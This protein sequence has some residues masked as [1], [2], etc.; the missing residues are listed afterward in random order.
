[1]KLHGGEVKDFEEDPKKF[2]NMDNHMDVR[3]RDVELFVYESLHHPYEIIVSIV[4]FLETL[5]ACGRNLLL[6][7]LFL[8]TFMFNSMASFVAISKNDLPYKLL[9]D[10]LHIHL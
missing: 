9:C 8:S 6:F 5:F 1:M 2:Q 7:L 3:A 4:I 10:S